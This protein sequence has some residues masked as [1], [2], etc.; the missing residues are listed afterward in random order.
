MLQRV[1]LDAETLAL[2]QQI[3]VLRR[4]AA[5]DL[6]SLYGL[7]IIGHVDRSETARLL[8]SHPAKTHIQNG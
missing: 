1:A 3:N 4:T 2:K 6:P 7:L 5:G 8:S